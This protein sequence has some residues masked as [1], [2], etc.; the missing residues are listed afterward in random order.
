MMMAAAWQGSLRA[1]RLSDGE[2]VAIESA[3]PEATEAFYCLSGRAQLSL[4]GGT[5]LLLDTSAFL[6]LQ[7]DRGETQRVEVAAQSGP[8]GLIRASVWPN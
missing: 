5:N 4:A 1:L 6:L 2:S 7:R 8:V 3:H